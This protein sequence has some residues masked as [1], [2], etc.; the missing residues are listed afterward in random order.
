MVS[1]HGFRKVS[2]VDSTPVRISGSDMLLMSHFV[3]L[4]LFSILSLIDLGWF[5]LLMIGQVDE[6]KE[7]GQSESHFFY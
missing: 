4:T 3:V 1:G 7:K 2:I 6:V 5:R